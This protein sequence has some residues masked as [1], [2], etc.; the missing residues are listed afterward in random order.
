V[1]RNEIP[2]T[3]GGQAVAVSRFTINYSDLTGAAGTTFTLNLLESPPYNTITNFVM[4]PG[5]MLAGL[6]YHPT[7]AFAGTG[8]AGLTLS[9]GN[10]AQ[11]ATFYSGPATSIWGAVSDITRT[12]IGPLFKRGLTVIVPTASSDPQLYFTATGGNLSALTA[13]SVDVYVYY[14]N[15]T[16]PVYA[17]VTPSIGPVVSQP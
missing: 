15:V 3:F 1:L 13:G 8:I 10:V 17:P 7:V 9:V 5:S 12:E 16:E 6:V 14:Y 4:A 2:L 11:G